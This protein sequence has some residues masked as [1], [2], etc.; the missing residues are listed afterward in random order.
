MTNGKSEQSKRMELIDTFS[1][2]RTLDLFSN[3]RNEMNSEGKV[4]S[5]VIVDYLVF[6]GI[7][8]EHD[9]FEKYLNFFIYLIRKKA[10]IT[11]FYVREF[12]HYIEYILII[13]TYIV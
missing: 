1:K 11:L 6:L 9:N 8:K 3:I 4:N 5:A 7:N 10:I 2:N 13:I 12:I